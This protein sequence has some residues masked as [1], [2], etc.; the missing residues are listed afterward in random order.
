MLPAPNVDPALITRV[1]GALAAH[2]AA[3][4]A[5]EVTDALWRGH[6]GYVTGTQDRTGLWRAQTPQGFHFE[7][8]LNAIAPTRRPPPTMSK[9]PA[10]PGWLLPSSK[11]PRTISRSRA[12]PILPALCI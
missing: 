11:A 10:G 1:I 2:D 6:D 12:S 7:A 4:P 3:A 9:S 8:I 5:V